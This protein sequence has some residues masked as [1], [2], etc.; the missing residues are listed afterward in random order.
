[1]LGADDMEEYERQRNLLEYQISFVPGS[2]EAVQKI[3]D[4]RKQGVG[5][6]KI[7]VSNDDFIKT[8]E[9]FDEF[10]LDSVNFIPIKG[11]E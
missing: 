9:M 5:D 4:E 6:H 3:W 7:I 10:E 2:G 11:N 1:M 8:L